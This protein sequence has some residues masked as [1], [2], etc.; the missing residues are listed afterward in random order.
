MG[1]LI[2]NP[3]I[4]SLVGGESAT[5]S[6]LLPTGPTSSR[7]ADPTAGAM[8]YNTTFNKLEVWNGAE[9]RLFA[10]EGLAVLTKDTFTGDGITT[11]FGPM[12]FSKAAG[13]EITTFV[14][15]GNVPQNPGVAYT[16]NGSTNITFTSPPPDTHTIVVL[17]GFDSTVAG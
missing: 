2:K 9:W 6:L 5:E 10:A 8:R 15:V 1:R 16:F 11:V 13:K 12:S 7:P 3:R 4:T 17:H 14:Y